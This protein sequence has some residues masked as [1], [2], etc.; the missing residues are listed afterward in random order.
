MPCIRPRI[1]QARV[2]RAD[3]ARRWWP[4]LLP[5]PPRTLELFT[6]WVHVTR[7]PQ[8]PTR[9]PKPFWLMWVSDSWHVKGTF[10]YRARV[11]LGVRGECFFALRGSGGSG[12]EVAP[13]AQIS[14]DLSLGCWIAGCE[15]GMLCLY[16]ARKSWPLENLQ[17]PSGQQETLFCFLIS[18]TPPPS[19]LPSLGSPRK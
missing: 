18:T 16:S 3:P 6:A 12:V 9:N 2:S 5:P 17:K 10:M 8:P 11:D 13:V 7:D 15:L 14:W 4:R 1:P 19:I